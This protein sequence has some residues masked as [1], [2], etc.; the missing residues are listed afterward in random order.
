MKK[1]VFASMTLMYGAALNLGAAEVTYD[2]VKAME[3]TGNAKIIITFKDKTNRSKL[4]RKSSLKEVNRQLKA[5]FKAASREVLDV[6]E[7]KGKMGAGEVTGQFW[8]ANAVSATV[9]KKML[10]RLSGRD[11]IAQITLDRVIM[12]EEPPQVQATTKDDEN[13]TYGLKKLGV[14]EVRQ[15]Y[16]LTGEGVTVAVLDTGIDAEHPD[17][18]GKVVAWKDWA[19]ESEEPKDAHGHG[20]HCAGTIAGGATSGRAIGVAPDAKLVIGRIFGDNGSATLSGILGA[21]NWVTDPDGDAE[22]NDAPQ[23]VSNSWGGRQGSMEQEK[24]MWNLVKTWRSLNIVPVFAAG[25]SGPWPRTV[26]TPG[27]YP[28]SYAVGATN[29]SDKAAYFSSRG[30][31]KW[32][33]VSYNKPDISAPGVGVLSAKPGGGYQK[34]SGTSM[35]CPHVAGLVA[36]M[37]Q[38]NPS[39]NVKQVEDL[40]N[41]S[42]VDL[43][44]DGLD[45]TYGHGRAD[46]KTTID[47]IKGARNGQEEKFNSLFTE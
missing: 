14:P 10:S 19:G 5:N 2:V 8:A 6:F 46:I 17:L 24:S 30:P 12:F 15:S 26:G 1:F 7:T 13:W 35:A 31:I 18:A 47:T 21:M 40:L 36:L 32:E 23:L 43:G 25:N 38:A 11:D 20:T 3:D 34:M 4:K 41:S 45:N 9:D 37:L 16:N 29:G 33:D 22:T 44:K 28:H 42:A 27:G 39:L